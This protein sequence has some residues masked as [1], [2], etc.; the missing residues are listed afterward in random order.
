MVAARMAVPFLQ[1]AELGRTCSTPPHKRGRP[2]LCH[3]ALCYAEF[4]GMIP[5]A[6]STYTYGYVGIYS[7]F[8]STAAGKRTGAR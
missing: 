6:G 5:V 8:G 7:N 1:E 3:A 4:T 2:C